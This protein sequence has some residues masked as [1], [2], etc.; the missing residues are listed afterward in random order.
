MVQ[1]DKKWQDT[2]YIW[3]GIVTVDDTKDDIPVSWEGTW[4]GG[5]GGS[6]KSQIDVSDVTGVAA[7]VVYNCQNCGGEAN[8]SFVDYDATL[9][10]KTLTADIGFASLTYERVGQYTLKGTFRF[11][12]GGDTANGT[13]VKQ[14]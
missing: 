6:C 14:Q 4:V 3:D 2:L 1:E 10:G 8:G 9:S 11:D 7:K 5:W 13:F 12:T